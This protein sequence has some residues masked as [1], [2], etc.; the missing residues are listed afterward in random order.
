MILVAGDSLAAITAASPTPYAEHDDRVA[1]SGFENL[2]HGG[3]AGLEAEDE[4]GR[5]SVAERGGDLDC[6]CGADDGS[7]GE[8]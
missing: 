1:E 6:C 8:R 3:G 7:G 5:A 4:W 2:D